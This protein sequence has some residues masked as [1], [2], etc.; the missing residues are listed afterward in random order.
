MG[1]SNGCASTFDLEVGTTPGG[2]DIARPGADTVG[3]RD[4]DVCGAAYHYDVI[5]LVVP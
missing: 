4:G 5:E 2:S 3:V 1:T